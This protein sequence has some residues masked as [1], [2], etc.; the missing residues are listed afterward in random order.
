MRTRFF[1]TIRHVAFIDDS[2]EILSDLMALQ[3]A[4]YP[5]RSAPELEN[6]ESPYN[7]NSPVVPLST[8][9]ERPDPIFI[10]ARFRTGSTLLWQLFRNIPGVTAYY[11]PFNERRWFDQSTC[12]KSVDS[13]HLGVSEYWSEYQNLSE[14]G[15]Y[16][17]EDW[18]RRQLCMPRTAWNPAM[19]RY[20]ELMIE[21]APG[22]AVLQFNR[23]DLR[24]PWL[25]ARFPRAKILHLY[26]NPREQWCSCLPKLTQ[27]MRSLR[28]ATFQPLMVTI[29]SNGAATC[30]IPSHS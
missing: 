13:T 26:R 8:A 25:R 18:T 3:N 7:A 6:F 23:V 4:T 17:S 15:Q 28:I 16:Y 14:L 30:G 24:L 20:I 1:R 9:R 29:Y 27:D 2:R 22:R 12:G 19:E 21:K 11:E 10:T 5:Q